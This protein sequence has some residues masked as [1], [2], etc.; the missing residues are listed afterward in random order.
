MEETAV[1]VSATQGAGLDSLLKNIQDRI[2]LS[3]GIFEKS[4]IVPSGGEELQ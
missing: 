2:V 1:S 3:K 4:F